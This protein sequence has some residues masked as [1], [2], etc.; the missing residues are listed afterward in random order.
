M[1]V[2]L[3]RVRNSHVCQFADY[4]R[5]DTR[6]DYAGFAPAN[7]SRSSSEVSDLSKA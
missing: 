2:L 5:C 6:G 3:V 1:A 7:E 4:S